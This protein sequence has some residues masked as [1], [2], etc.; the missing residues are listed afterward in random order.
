MGYLHHL[1]SYDEERRGR[2]EMDTQD[3]SRLLKRKQEGQDK[4]NNKEKRGSRLDYHLMLYARLCTTIFIV[5][6]LIKMPRVYIDQ[7]ILH[8]IAI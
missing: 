1:C 5:Y 6:H 2:L 4:T 8:T 3:T 7:G